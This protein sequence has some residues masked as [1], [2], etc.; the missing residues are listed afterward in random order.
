MSP[1]VGDIAALIIIGFALFV[2]L[3][4]YLLEYLIITRMRDDDEQDETQRSREIAL[5]LVTT[6]PRPAER[7]SRVAGKEELVLEKYSKENSKDDYG[8]DM[9]CLE[10]YKDGDTR[11]V[12]TACNHRFH[13]VCIKTWLVQNDTCP[14]CRT[15]VV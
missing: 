1:H 15:L 10:E 3:V 5:T 14:L 6:P 12:I 13:A 7:R 11:A 8:G 9:I 2:T 4:I